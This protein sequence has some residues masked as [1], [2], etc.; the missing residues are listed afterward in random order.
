M[1]EL[2][3]DPFRLPVHRVVSGVEREDTMRGLFQA[4]LRIGDTGVSEE[5]GA[6]HLHVL[7]P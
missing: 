5:A 6:L 3:R 4:V 7:L 2:A 1:V